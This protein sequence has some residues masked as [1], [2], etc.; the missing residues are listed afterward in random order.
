MDTVGQRIRKRREEFGWNQENLAE[1][2]G[3]HRNTI[4]KYENDSNVPTDIFILCQLTI[5]LRVPLEYLLTEECLDILSKNPAHLASRRFAEQLNTAEKIA[6]V[7]QI[8]QA[9]TAFHP[10]K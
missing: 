4:A 5:A 6:A 3:I 7:E 2:A 8:I 9:T 1:E 10:P